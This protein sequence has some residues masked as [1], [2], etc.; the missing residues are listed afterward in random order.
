MRRRTA[1]SLA[2]RQIYWSDVLCLFSSIKCTKSIVSLS[3]VPDALLAFRFN[4]QLAVRCCI[5]KLS[6]MPVA[7]RQ[8]FLTNRNS[9]TAEFPMRNASHCFDFG[10]SVWIFPFESV[11]SCF[12]S[13][14]VGSM[15]LGRSYVPFGSMCVCVCLYKRSASNSKTNKTEEKKSA[16]QTCCGRLAGTHTLILHAG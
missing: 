3:M 11:H 1:P 2:Q 7:T 4:E 16:Q 6:I 8:T 15:S 10:V 5:L 14:M 12:G 9:Y 13:G